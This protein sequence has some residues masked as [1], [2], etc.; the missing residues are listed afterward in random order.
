MKTTCSDF[1]ITIEETVETVLLNEVT[2]RFRRDIQTKGR[3]AALTKIT[4]PDCTL[5]VGMMTKFSCFEHSQSPELPAALPTVDEL[6]AD[7]VL[8]LNWIDEFVKR[9]P[10]T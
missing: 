3:L 6:E 1:R 2:L 8:M 5:V 9:E 4:T 7:T 10:K